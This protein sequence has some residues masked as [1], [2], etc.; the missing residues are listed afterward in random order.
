VPHDVHENKLLGLLVLGQDSLL[1]LSIKVHILTN[2][3]QKIK[4]I[5]RG[6]QFTSII[7]QHSTL[8]SSL[9]WV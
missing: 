7:F 5:E 1:V 8:T 4:L 9:S 3:T 6:M 2:S